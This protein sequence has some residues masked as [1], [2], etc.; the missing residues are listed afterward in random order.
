[1]S[2]R[3]IAHLARLCC[4]AAVVATTGAHAAELET[5]DQKTIYALGFAVNQRLGL[6]S[7]ALSP[8]EFDLMVAGL[9]DAVTGQAPKVAMETY[10]P[11]ISSFGQARASQAAQGEKDAAAAFLSTEASAEGATKQPSGLIKRTVKA[12]SG[13]SPAA[14]DTVRVHYHGTLRDGTV[15]DSSVERGTPAEFPL[16]RVIPCWT[17]AVQAMKVG[18]KAHIT[19]PSEIAYGDKG[20]PPKIKGG[21]AL[22][23]DVELLEIVKPA[24]AEMTPKP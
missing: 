22:A 14:T 19:C 23:F 11:K 1:M 9:R 7:F 17:E 8:A 18:E 15:F 3:S 4:V 16:N 24:G 21:A 13:E 5:E 12:G 6:E 20:F 2:I 10:G